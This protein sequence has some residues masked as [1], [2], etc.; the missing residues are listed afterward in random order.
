MSG[1]L[2]GEGHLKE[3][4]LSLNDRTS[5]E[6]DSEV[7]EDEP[8]NTQ[9]TIA[10]VSVAF[11]AM[12]APLLGLGLKGLSLNGKPFF[13]NFRAMSAPLLGLESL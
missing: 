6:D 9:A 12:S 8:H 7:F 13:F 5:D 2:F 11:R 4:V 1:S 3:E 10:A